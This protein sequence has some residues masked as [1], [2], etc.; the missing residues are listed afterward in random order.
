[1][2]IS[3]ALTPMVTEALGYGLTSIIYGILVV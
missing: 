1:M 2:I 3:I